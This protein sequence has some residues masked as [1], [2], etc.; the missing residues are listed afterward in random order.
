MPVS[1][2]TTGLLPSCLFS[3]AS[4]FCIGHALPLEYLILDPEKLILYFKATF[5]WHLL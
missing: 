5:R 3:H 2:E 1:E 4:V